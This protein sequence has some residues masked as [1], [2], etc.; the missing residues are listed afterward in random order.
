MARTAAATAARDVRRD[1]FID[2]ALRLIQT[3][4][5][6][7]M[8]I[9]DILDELGVSRGALYHYFDSKSALLDAAMERMLETGTAIAREVAADPSMTATEKFGA[10]FT[11]IASWKNA[12]RELMLQLLEIW[13]SDENAIVLQRLRRGMT[14]RMTPILAEII[15]QGCDE[16]TFTVDSAED[17]AQLCVALIQGTQEIAADLYVA[18]GQDRIPLEVVERKFQFFADGYARILGAPPGSLRFIDEE[19]IRLWFGDEPAVA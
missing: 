13:Y 1:A 17:A 5:Y 7:Q 18:R 3:K 9:Q 8:S 4:G 14:E 16:G 6:E 19:T 11:N 15:G 10:V 2:A 12:R